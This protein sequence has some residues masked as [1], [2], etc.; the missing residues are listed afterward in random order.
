MLKI[1]LKASL[2]KCEQSIKYFFYRKIENQFTSKNI[3]SSFI[4][5]QM[6]S[7]NKKVIFV[8]PISFTRTKHVPY[9]LHMKILD[10]W[11]RWRPF[12]DRLQP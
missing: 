7:E 4:H 9:T 2:I 1:E 8:E 11:V 6:D 3:N 12:Q 10:L 5:N